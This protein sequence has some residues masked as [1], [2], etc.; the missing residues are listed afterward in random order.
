MLSGGI[1]SKFLII[2]EGHESWLMDPEVR[3]QRLRSVILIVNNA[4]TD[5]TSIVNELSTKLHTSRLLPA[6]QISTID[7]VFSPN[8]IECIYFLIFSENHR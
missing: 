2:H 5:P 3:P 7:K 1:F 8:K 6:Q 4:D